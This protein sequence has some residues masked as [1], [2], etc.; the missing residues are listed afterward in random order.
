MLNRKRLNQSGDTIIEVLLALMIIGLVI[1]SAMNLSHRSLRAQQTSQERT[2]ASNVAQSVIEVINMYARED[3]PDVFDLASNVKCVSTTFN[4]EMFAGN[5]IVDYD[6]MTPDARCFS[7]LDGR[8]LTTVTIT[9]PDPA[10]PFSYEY[11]VNTVW[12]GLDAAQNNVEMR[13]KFT[14]IMP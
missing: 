1:A 11:E 12:D 8:Y 4:A 13:Y 14:R 10:M 2:E 6:P 5:A 3:N 7:G 9:A